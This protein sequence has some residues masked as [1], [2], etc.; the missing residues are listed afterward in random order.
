MMSI[1]IILIA[2]IGINILLYTCNCNSILY[3]IFYHK[4]YLIWKEVCK[5]AIDCDLNYDVGWSTNY[6]YKQYTICLWHDS[7]T[8]SIHAPGQGCIFS[9]FDR[10]RSM[11]LYEAVQNSRLT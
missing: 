7:K 4:K 8:A 3:Y 2:A 5:H 9:T 6:N 10:K 11:K 1:L